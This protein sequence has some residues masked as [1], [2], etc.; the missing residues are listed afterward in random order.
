MSSSPAETDDGLYAEAGAA[1]D[2]LATLLAGSG[3]GW[4]FGNESPGEFD[5][6][7]F[8][9]T[10]LLLGPP[11]EGGLG[12]ADSRLADLARWAGGGELYAH[13]ERVWDCFWKDTE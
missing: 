3:T 11:E 13:R 7:V 2:A 8:A 5:A 1:L 12:W 9:Y 10:Q 6:A 4:F